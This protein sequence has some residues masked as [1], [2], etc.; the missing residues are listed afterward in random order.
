MQPDWTIPEHTIWILCGTGPQQSDYIVKSYAR[1]LARFCRYDL[2]ERY[3]QWAIA[4]EY[5]RRW[6]L[7]HGDAQRGEG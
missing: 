3:R 5:K 4:R 6:A 7:L 1:E 2:A